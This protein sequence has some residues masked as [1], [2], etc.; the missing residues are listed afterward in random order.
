MR[1]LQYRLLGSSCVLGSLP[2]MLEQPWAI[3]SGERLGQ[4]AMARPEPYTAEGLRSDLGSAV[5]HAE[6]RL[7]AMRT[8]LDM[9]SRGAGFSWRPRGLLQGRGGPHARTGCARALRS[10]INTFCH[11]LLFL[12]GR[13]RSCTLGPGC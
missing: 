13:S 9:I 5:R 11:C 2:S 3:N 4:A 10:A 12:V 8:A 6:S 7:A 1:E